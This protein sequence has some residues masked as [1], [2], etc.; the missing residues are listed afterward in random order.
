[1][2]SWANK[3]VKQYKRQYPPVIPESN[4]KNNIAGN[5]Y[6]GLSILNSPLWVQQK[7]I[8]E[9][10]YRFDLIYYKQ[11][12]NDVSMLNDNQIYNHF[13]NICIPNNVSLSDYDYIVDNNFEIN[14]SSIKNKDMIINHY[15]IR[16]IKS[17]SELLEYRNTLKTN[18]IYN[19]ETLYNYYY[20]LDLNFY[21]NT[22]LNNDKTIS[23]FDIYLHYHNNRKNL[24][25]NKKL[26]VIY[27]PPYDIKIGGIVVMH[28]LCKIINEKF[29]NTY[30]A[31]LFMHN[32]IR[33]KNE[34]LC[35]LVNTIIIKRTTR[36]II[37]D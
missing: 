35:N 15:Y 16:N 33:Y 31:K 36:N 29:G 13:M 37:K 9:L 20:D 34:V 18:Y 7:K 25:N 28:N 21:R 17:Y 5:T 23:D 2:S 32:N 6:T 27:S 1:M 12:N 4:F 3:T 22:Y 19:K 30:K 11:F 10:K 8:I 24:R 26:I 14:E